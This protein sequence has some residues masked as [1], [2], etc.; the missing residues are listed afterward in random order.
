MIV[1]LISNRLSGKAYVGQTK[2]GLEHR[3][4]EHVR[5]ALKGR[6]E[7]GLYYAIRKHGADA[8]DTFVLEECSSDEAMDAAEKRWIAELG[9]YGGGYNQTEGGDGLKGYHH[10]EATKKRMSEY[11]KGRP[12]GPCPEERKKKIS[13][14]KKG[15]GTGPRPLARGWHHSDEA[16]QKIG[17]SSAIRKRKAVA[18]CD[19]HGTVLAVYPSINEAAAALN[20]TAGKISDVLNGRAPRYRGFTWRYA[21]VTNTQNLERS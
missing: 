6:T 15:T 16:R 7:M 12:L 1:Y 9:T 8:F 3:W 20:G 4:H 19:V 17:A 14:G 2:R 13:E 18:R 21:D 5:D 11:R 10:T